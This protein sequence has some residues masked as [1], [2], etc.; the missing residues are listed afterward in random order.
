[1]KGDPVGVLNGT[2]RQRLTG[3]IGRSYFVAAGAQ[4]GSRGRKSKR[5]ATHI[6]SG[7][8]YDAHGC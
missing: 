1:M 2:G 4:P 8:Q 6:V 3:K 7:N 5:L